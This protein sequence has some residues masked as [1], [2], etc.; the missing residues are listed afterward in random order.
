M[1][2]YDIGDKLL[3]NVDIYQNHKDQKLSTLNQHFLDT[4][5]FIF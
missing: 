3:K 4:C 2:R 1:L 5:F